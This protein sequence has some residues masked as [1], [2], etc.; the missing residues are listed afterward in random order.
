VFGRTALDVAEIA[1]GLPVGSAPESRSIRALHRAGVTHVL[2]LREPHEGSAAE[3]PHGVVV[4][5]T[6]VADGGHPSTEELHDVVSWVRGARAA[7]GR[8]HVARRRLEPHLA[9]AT[10]CIAQQPSD[11]RA[12]RI[13]GEP[14]ATSVTTRRSDSSAVAGTSLTERCGF[15][16]SRTQC[17]K[18]SCSSLALD[19]SGRGWAWG[20]NQYG[21]LGNGN[22]SDSTTPVAVSMPVGVSFGAIAA[23]A[24]HSLALTL[25][26][27]T[28][29]PE[30]PLLML[31]PLGG[32]LAVG[33]Y[34][35]LRPR[36]ATR[37]RPRVS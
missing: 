31:L 10:G 24:Y 22:T 36:V 9:A 7:G 4:R 23:G 16:P 11:G 25:A 20:S 1:P 32:L 13:R 5:Q 3:W 34:R 12:P 35:L 2:D 26:P 8:G 37:R 28:T 17:Q 27:A 18:S 21:Q 19:S 6:P 15:T 29:V 30:V 33:G 14:S